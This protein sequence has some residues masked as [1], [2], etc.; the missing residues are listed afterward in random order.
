MRILVYNIA[1]GT[2]APKSYYDHINT[3]SRYMRT[4]HTHLDEIMKF[5][6][7]ADPD[8]LGLVE[9]D[10]GSYRT[11]AVNQV[12]KI[13]TYLNH[14][15]Q[16]SVKYKHKFLAK[17]LPIFRNQ[18]NAILTKDKMP[19]GKFHYFSRGVKRLIIEVNVGGLRFFL[20]HLAL[21]KEVRK[22]QLAHL[23]KLAKGRV[24]VIIAGDFNTF[25]GAQEIEEF[26]DSLG[27]INPN[28]DA[29]P[30]FPSWKPK[31][32]LDFILCSKYLKIRNFEIPKVKFSDH[33]P[34]ILD[35]KI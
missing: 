26:Q 3:A 12:E 4:S 7:K 35:L 15:H 25:S 19:Q 32:Q 27:L 6:A 2:G 24:P 20:V 33:L 30:T 23:A 14:H 1:Y 10:T 28:I 9:I 8:V 29:L 16:S 11:K 5:I 34:L 31:K 21:R 17:T 22:I 18:A 13:A